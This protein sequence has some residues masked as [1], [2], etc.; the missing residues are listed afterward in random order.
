M[1]L[2]EDLDKNN[3]S[4]T[5]EITLDVELS[6]DALE[7]NEKEFSDAEEFQQL[8]KNE[9]KDSEENIKTN[10]DRLEK[11]MEDVKLEKEK[12]NEEGVQE[13][14]KS[15]EETNKDK[16]CT[17]LHWRTAAKNDLIVSVLLFKHKIWYGNVCTGNKTDENGQKNRHK[18]T[19]CTWEPGIIWME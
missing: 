7:S 15:S 8:E 12:Q 5:L 2:A 19:R 18:N 6:T 9:R 13:E 3:K 10:E 14:S 4:N 16:V 11:T 17:D 1:D